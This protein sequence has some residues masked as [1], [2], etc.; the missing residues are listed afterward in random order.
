LY[1]DSVVRNHVLDSL[2]IGQVLVHWQCCKK[3]CVRQFVYR[4]ITCTLTV[5]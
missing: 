3:P 1:I 2:Y 4:T 5:L